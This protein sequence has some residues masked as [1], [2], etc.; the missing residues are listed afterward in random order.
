MKS[1]SLPTSAR[2]QLEEIALAIESAGNTAY[3]TTK[4]LK[5]ND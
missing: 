2:E 5:S 4:P 1:E 3:K